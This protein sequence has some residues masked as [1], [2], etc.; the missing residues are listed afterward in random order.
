MLST[1]FTISVLS[2]IGGIGVGLLALRVSRVR[3]W[4]ELRWFAVIAFASAG[5]AVANLS[6]T[7]RAPAA[8]VI[9]ASHIQASLALV[10]YWAWLRYARAFGR[11][12]SSVFGRWVE[13]LALAG[14]A[15]CLVPGLAFDGTIAHHRFP[16]WDVTYNDARITVPGYALLLTVGLPVVPLT[17]ARFVRAHRDGVRHAPAQAAAFVSIVLLSVSDAITGTGRFAMPYLL[18][19]GF[20]L[21]VALV[22]WATSLRFLE[23]AQDLEVLRGRLESLVEARTRALAEAKEALVRAERLASLGQLANG[24]AHQVSNPASVVTANLRFLSENHG[25][26]GEIREV[27]DE[28][29]AAMQRINDLV[30][31]LADTGRIA[32]MHRPTTGVE[33]REV[34][35]R[36]VAEARMRLGG[37]FTL[38]TDVPAGLLV[39]T[40]P[41]VLEQVL[42]SLLSNAVE[43]LRPGRE[44]RIEI[45]AERRDGGIRLTVTDDGIGMP[46]GVLERAF[47]PFFTTKPPGLG[48]GLSLAI[49]RGVVEAHG[50]ALRLES[51]PGGGTTAV[52]ALPESAPVD[53]GSAPDL[54][55]P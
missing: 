55:P 46:S 10:Q 12:P 25:G 30:R 29:L 47:E 54:R 15:A 49:S 48:S 1:P 36:A 14:A 13:W 37:E 21:P 43:A 42:Q 52:L 4:G 19:I 3:G 24:V 6:A 34:V 9:A 26:S 51:T 11:S 35:E 33:L 50:G 45:R 23:S 40:R 2:T 44:G 31:R 39:R 53:A 17:L 5:Y 38:D 22:A 20:L 7:L 16:L 32:A 28:A 18:D 41:E 27:A 8:L